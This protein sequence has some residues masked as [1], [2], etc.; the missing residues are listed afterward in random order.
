[1][2]D[3]R[4]DVTETGAD[5][6]LVDGDLAIDEGLETAVI[7]SLFSDARV[8]PDELLPEEVQ[9]VDDPAYVRETRGFWADTPEDRWGSKLYLLSRAKATDD[10]ATRA[11]RFAEESLAWMLRD[12]IASRI[13]VA[14]EFVELQTQDRRPEKVLSIEIGISRGTASRWDSLWQAFEGATFDAPG[15]RVRLLSA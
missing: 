5:L 10:T 3:L 14:A 8:G 13:D 7:V 1:M 11:A 2:T 12:G 4:L 6:L 9:A 15:V